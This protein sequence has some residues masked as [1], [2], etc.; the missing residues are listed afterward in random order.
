MAAFNRL[1]SLSFLTVTL[2]LGFPLVSLAQIPP[3]ETV[4]DLNQ[5]VL[6]LIQEG[7]YPTALPLAEQALE[8]GE[9]IWA[10]DSVEL[11]PLLHNLGEIYQHTGDYK[12]AEALYQRA[13]AIREAAYGTNHEDVGTSLNRLGV[14][15]MEMGQFSEAEALFK[16]AL[17]IYEQVLGTD[18]PKVAVTLTNLGQLYQE[19]GDY[20]A[21]EASLQRAIA[22][23]EASYGTEDARIAGSLTVLAFLYMETG[24]YSQAEPLLQRV[25]GLQESRWGRD[26]PWVAQSLNGLA[27][28]YFETGNYEAAEPLLTRSLQI[29]EA[30]LG[31]NHPFLATNLNNLASLKVKLADYAG[32]VPLFERS[33]RI[34]EEQLGA[35]HPLVALNLHN[36]AETYRNLEQYEQAETLLKRAIALREKLLSPNHPDLA[37]SLNNLAEV[38]RSMGNFSE[39]EP[40]LRQSLAIYRRTLGPDHPDIATTLNNL[41]WLSQATGNIPDA[42]SF[43]QQSTEIEENN[44]D[45]FL[46]VSSEGQKQAYM[47]SFANITNRIVSLH[48]QDAPDNPEVAQLALT[49]ILRRKGRILDTLTDSRQRLRQ[50]L[51]PED[52]ILLDRETE[53]RS[54]LAQLIF[55]PPKD[56]ENQAPYQAQVAQLKAD[57]DQL[58]GQLAR[59]SSEFRRRTEPVTITAVQQLIPAQ[60]ALVEVILYRPVNAQTNT[61]GEERYAAYI[62]QATGKPQWVDLGEAAEINQIAQNLQRLTARQGNLERLQAQARQLDELILRPIRAKLSNVDHLLLSPDGQLNLLSWATLIDENQQYAIENYRLTYLSTGRDLL[63]LETVAAAR[64]NPVILANPDYDAPGETVEIASGLRGENQ[65][66]VDLQQLYFSPLPGT[67]QEADAIAPLLPNATILTQSQATENA[68]KQVTAPEILH[69]AT[70]GFFLD[71]NLVAPTANPFASRGSL[72]VYALDNR[73]LVATRSEKQENPLLRSG[74]ALAG[75]NVRSSEGEDGVLTALEAANLD[76]NGTQLVVLSACETGVGEIANGE[77]VYGLR[78]AFAIAGAQSQLISLWQVSDQGTKDLM[79]DYYQRLTQ[80]TG[81]SEAL[82]QVQIAMLQNAEYQHPFFWGA[83]IPSGQWG[84]LREWGLGSRQ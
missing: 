43:L 30:S 58:E 69:I 44:L 56:A 62:L 84:L 42:Y 16:R 14:L 6:D 13:L 37:L 50:N 34:Y 74:L 40:Y 51:T 70:H 4:Q 3:I 17:Q 10:E 72:G 20:E 71:V 66:S 79:V 24:R 15:Y 36:L 47:S 38:Y 5:Q 76:L 26:H 41:A 65:R 54:Q 35:E 77:G 2:N 1:L 52:R 19:T 46:T 57:I 64:Q 63:G 22:L 45:L 8:M 11:T 27:W 48:L 61:W 53:M 29:Y 82:R 67:A 33:L 31:E 12:A 78:R 81:R 60:T 83:F 55:N 75:F 28:L 39:A 25:I 49:T 23:E 80:G 73:A 7:Q 9:K 68:L 32:A 21:A 18:D 59:R